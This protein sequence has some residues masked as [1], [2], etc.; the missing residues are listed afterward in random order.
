MKYP[1][2]IVNKIDTAF[3][4]FPAFSQVLGIA[5]LVTRTRD[6][7]EKTDV[8][9]AVYK[10]GDCEYAGIDDTYPVVTYHRSL[11]MTLSRQPKGGYG[12]DMPDM[13]MSHAMS[14]VI[15]AK[16]DETI[17]SADSLAMDI[18]HKFP[19]QLTG[20]D[21]PDG[22]KTV[23]ININDIVLSETQVFGEEYKNVPFFLGPE[24]ILIKV[25]YTIE[26]TYRKGCSTNC[27]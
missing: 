23:V 4:M 14:L 7:S 6:A 13:K 16:K 8:W 2:C 21:L 20:A 3:G 25:N 1:D 5:Q 9:P 10:G 22:L 12:D 18:Q 19:D 17:C 26:S 27:P 11:K 15:F 24:H